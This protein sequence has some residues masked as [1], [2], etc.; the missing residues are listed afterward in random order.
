MADNEASLESGQEAWYIEPPFD[1]LAN[2]F[3]C[4]IQTVSAKRVALRFDPHA[5]T[6]VELHNRE[7]IVPTH[8]YGTRF[9][10]RFPPQTNADT[11]A[12]D[13]LELF[14]RDL[15]ETRSKHGEIYTYAGSQLLALNLFSSPTNFD[16]QTMRRYLGVEKQREDN[17]AH[18]YAVLNDMVNA[19]SRDSK[20]QMLVLNSNGP[21]TGIS[22]TLNQA[23]SFFEMAY[24]SSDAH[25]SDRVTTALYIMHTF[26]NAK[27][28]R[29]D[30]SCRATL[31]VKLGVL[32]NEEISSA[33]VQ[34]FALDTSR[35]VFQGPCERN[36]H[37][38]YQLL[39]GADE[40]MKV[41]YHLR[42]VSTYKYLNR[43]INNCAMEDEEPV[44]FEVRNPEGE[45]TKDDATDFQDLMSLLNAVAVQPAK[46]DHILRTLSAVLLIGDLEFSGEEAALLVNPEL[47]DQIADLLRLPDAQAL[48]ASFVK[49]TRH[50][51]GDEPVEVAHL[52]KQ[53]ERL[54]DALAEQLYSTLVDFVAKAV[55]W[56]PEE[57]TE[58]F[59]AIAVPTTAEFLYDKNIDARRNYCNRYPQ[60]LRLSLIHI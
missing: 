46:Q 30:D 48:A 37:V 55:S 57:M 21:G 8:S 11:L 59:H 36:Y 6:P 23:L 5:M 43:R 20:S 32:G 28:S 39:A 31:S 14:V 52:P 1:L 33:V 2:H 45:K 49:C 7:M 26:T 58:N 50:V 24:G 10:R 15:L 40:E 16:A 35:V 19:L 47:C 29:N 60:L 51:V 42:D 9:C 34:V 44:C 4:S 18:L 41:K 13:S 54:R 53:A 17:P 12:D 25:F 38:F 27:M 22:F 56:R 3:P